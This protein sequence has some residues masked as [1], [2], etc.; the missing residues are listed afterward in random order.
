MSKGDDENKE[1]GSNKS[2]RELRRRNT[3]DG[4]EITNNP[5]AET[6]ADD[7]VDKF[8]GAGDQGE[9]YRA[10][11]KNGEEVALKIPISGYPDYNKMQLLEYTMKKA[12]R[13][14]LEDK[15]D[16]DQDRVNK[17]YNI[18]KSTESFVDSQKQHTLPFTMELRREG[19]AEDLEDKNPQ[20]YIKE[21]KQ[22]EKLVSRLDKLGFYLGEDIMKDDNLYVKDDKLQLGDCGGV[23]V[24]KGSTADKYFQKELKKAEEVVGAS[25]LKPE[26]IYSDRSLQA[27]KSGK[28]L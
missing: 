21:K 16:P 26:E 13:Q 2:V 12:M 27:E 11:H 22:I 6:H 28:N 20:L 17:V 18:E 14:V 4:L 3:L 9:V 5:R 1:V 23:K 8:I 10:T 7:E 24:D 15:G 25:K 19:T